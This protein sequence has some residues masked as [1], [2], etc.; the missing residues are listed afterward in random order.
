M[1]SCDYVTLFLS[2]VATLRFPL[3]LFTVGLVEMRSEEMVDELIDSSI[4]NPKRPLI[5]SICVSQ[6]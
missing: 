3:L 1:R 5:D 4:N 2:Y 6:R